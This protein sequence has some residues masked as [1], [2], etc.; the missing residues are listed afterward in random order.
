MGGPTASATMEI[1]S[2][3][4]CAGIAD[5]VN[6][7]GTWV[8]TSSDTTYPIYYTGE[9]LLFNSITFNAELTTEN[10]LTLSYGGQQYYFTR[11]T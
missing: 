2:N 5:S 10:A 4:T 8:R 6:F 1:Y 11:A 3:G 9:L 7:N